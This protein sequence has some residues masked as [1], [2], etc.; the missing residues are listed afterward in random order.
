M[1]TKG[2]PKQT[3]LERFGTPQTYTTAEKVAF[4]D[5]GLEKLKS[6]KYKLD[7][8]NASTEGMARE[9]LIERLKHL[10]DD[11][12]ISKSETCIELIEALRYSLDTRFMGKDSG[13][14]IDAL[15]FH[16]DK[17]RASRA[18]LAKA[19]NREEVRAT[20]T[21]FLDTQK[22]KTGT[23]VLAGRLRENFPD[24]TPRAAE[25]AVRAWKKLRSAGKT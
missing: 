13:E 4:F 14:V 15:A 8:F 9:K 12:D 20:Q 25:D 17:Q 3:M 22:D 23:H 16:F 24:M 21:A 10:S 11:P 2:K 5:A 6:L 7:T 1:T 19:G 18:G